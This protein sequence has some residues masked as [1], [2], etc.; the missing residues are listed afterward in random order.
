[1]LLFGATVWIFHSTVVAN[2]AT[3]VSTE[4]RRAS[5]YWYT[6]ASS[7]VGSDK[8]LSAHDFEA[9]AGTSESI[10]RWPWHRPQRKEGNAGRGGFQH[11]VVP[12]SIIG[13]SFQAISMHA[14]EAVFDY[15][16]EQQSRFQ[17]AS[18][19]CASWFALLGLFVSFGYYKGAGKSR[20]RA[21][22][23]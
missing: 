17:G 2:A 7:F 10:S 14:L 4:V 21:S 9:F 1:M 23:G 13:N 20:G 11:E 16:L 15:C 6:Y 12:V 22:E 3:T 8:N 18:M 5:E 19:F